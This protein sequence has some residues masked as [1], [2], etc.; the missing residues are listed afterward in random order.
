MYQPCHTPSGFA[1]VDGSALPTCA[2]SPPPV[3][4][5]DD[6]DRLIAFRQGLLSA[7]LFGLPGLFPAS[8]SAT[9]Q[10]QLLAG[11]IDH[12][13]TGP[14]PLTAWGQQMLKTAQTPM[15]GAR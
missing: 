4:A 11:W 6:F 8:P 9:R 2:A 12:G 10:G 15:R 14:V 3:H 5:A 7:R 1:A 13:M